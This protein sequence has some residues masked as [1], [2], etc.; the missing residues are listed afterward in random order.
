M[1]CTVSRLKDP[2]KL[3]VGEL[4]FPPTEYLGK[5][6]ED[7]GEGACRLII[8]GDGS[9]Q[10]Q[11]P[12]TITEWTLRGWREAPQ[13]CV[14]EGYVLCIHKSFTLLLK[15]DNVLSVDGRKFKRGE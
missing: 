2:A 4:Q 15:E 6:T 5:W 11:T 12:N 13:P 10:W 3:E 1:G 8:E 14:V 7:N 9:A